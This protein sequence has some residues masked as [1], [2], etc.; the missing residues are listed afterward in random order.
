MTGMQDVEDAVGEHH[1]LALGARAPGKR[2][3]FTSGH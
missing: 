1:P 2:R 3:C